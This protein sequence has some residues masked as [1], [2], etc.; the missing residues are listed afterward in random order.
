LIE[1]LKNIK[2]EVFIGK[3]DKIIDVDGAVKFFRNYA[4]VYLIKDV[5]HLL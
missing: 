4:D 2:V 5:G 1:H 3:E